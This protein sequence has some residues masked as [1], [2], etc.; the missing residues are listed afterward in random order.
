MWYII[1]AVLTI[2][3]L[4]GLWLLFKKAGKQGWEAIVPFYREYVMA[5][6]TARPTWWVVLLL[7]PIVNIFIFYGLYLDFL[8]CFGKRRFWETAVAVLLPFIYLPLWGRDSNVRYLGPSNTEEFRKKYPYKK[9]VAREWADAIIFAT[10]AASLI[11]G[12]L[13]EAYMIPTGS[14]ERSL[15]IGDFLFV[16]KLNYG[17]RVPMT[18]LAFPFAHHTMPVTGGKA[19]SELVQLP[20]KRLPGFQEIKRNDVVV[21]NFPAGDT[22]VLEHQDQTYADMVR[23]MGKEAVHNQFTVVTR[24]I[25]KRENYIKRCVGLPGDVIA[26]EG[27]KLMVNGQPGFTPPEMQM[28]Y[29]VYTDQSGLNP[30]RMKDLRLE[31]YPTNQP[32]IFRVFMTADEAEV[33]KAWGNVKSVEMGTLDK[34]QL[35]GDT[36]PHD[37]H[38]RWNFDNFGPITIPAKGWTVSLDSLSVPMYARAIRDYEGNT[39]EK[40]GDGYYINGQKS[41]TY[42]FKQN[43]YW[44]VGDNRHNS[45]DSRAWG[46]V[47]EDHIVGKALFTWMSYDE[48]GSFLSKIRWNRIFKGIN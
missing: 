27:A 28:D 22:V 6:L 7:V 1:F 34:S 11:R 44:M 17:P 35:L 31:Y 10:V 16:S 45:L 21:F 4:Y 29:Y 48:N 42:T 38:Y 39:L 24:P 15:L 2:A 41:A 13:I 36:Y 18:P 32:D 25:D 12:F 43:Y 46:F 9:S 37:N 40:R 20:Y 3:S 8:K 30:E 47:P 5:Q 26:M 14:M 23:Y 33:V 19:Y